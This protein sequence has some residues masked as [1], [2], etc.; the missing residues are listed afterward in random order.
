MPF[1]SIII[2]TYNRAEFLSKTISTIFSQSFQD[3]EIIVVDDGSKDDTVTILENIKIAHQ[4]FAFYYYSQT[5]AER[6]AARNFGIDKATGKYITFLDSDDILYPDYFENAFQTLKEQN[7]P[8]FLHTAYEIKTVDNQVLY[9]INR[10]K[11]DDYK[12]LIEGNPLS[13]M[14]W[15]LDNEKTKNFRFPEDRNIA[16]SEDWAFALILVA[17]FGIKIS[18]TITAALIHHEARSVLNFNEEQLETRTKLA[19]E[20]AL[21]DEKTNEVYGKHKVKIIAYLN[22]YI[23]LHLALSNHKKQARKYLFRTLKANPFFCFERRFLA[24]IKHLIF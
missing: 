10:L 18:H 7:F 24:I 16:G 6:G 15:F 12:M 21:K 9:K 23:A 20:Y 13:C 4:N 19:L 5:N 22:A 3:F 2:P 14:G 17:H 11:N 1:F 8:T